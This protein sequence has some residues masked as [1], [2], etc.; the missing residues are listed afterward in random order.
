MRSTTLVS[1]GSISTNPVRPRAPSS[2]IWKTLDSASSRIV[3]VSLPCG[4]SADVAISSPTVTNRRS[5]ERSR[6]ISA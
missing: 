1:S 5:T 4:F 3:L 2:A 6:T